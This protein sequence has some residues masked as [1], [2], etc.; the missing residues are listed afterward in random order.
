MVELLE[1]HKKLRAI[2]AGRRPARVLYLYDDLEYCTIYGIMKPYRYYSN[3]LHTPAQDKFNKVM[4]ILRIK[5]EHSFAIHQNLW[6]WNGFHL[7]LKV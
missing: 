5:V 2:N 4:A 1:L 7:Q 3:C 6:T